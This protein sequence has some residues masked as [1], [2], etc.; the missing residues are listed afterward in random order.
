MTKQGVDKKTLQLI[1]RVILEEAG[2]LGVEVEKII[3]FG[4]RARGD[5]RPDSDYD[6]LVVVKREIGWRTRRRLSL[7]IRRRLYPLLKRPIDLIIE[8][9]RRFKERSPLLG[10]LEEIAT[11]EGITA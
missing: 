1:R 2:K 7:N 11:K 6:I 4:S 10:S 3:L 9:E 8:D 5:A